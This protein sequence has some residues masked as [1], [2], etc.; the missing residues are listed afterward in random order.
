MER[1][2]D[3]INRRF[4]EKERLMQKQVSEDREDKLSFWRHSGIDRPE[5]GT[6]LSSVAG[7]IIFI[8]GLMYYLFFFLK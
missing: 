6:E 8:A 1:Y 5:T 7:L 3:Y 4:A 2:E